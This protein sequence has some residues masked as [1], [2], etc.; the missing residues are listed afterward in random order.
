[1]DTF[2]TKKSGDPLKATEW[3]EATKRIVQLEGGFQIGSNLGTAGK[4]VVGNTPHYQRVVEVTG[5]GDSDGMYKC[6]YRYYA[7]GDSGAT[8]DWVTAD[9]ECD[10]D[11]RALDITLSE[12][13]KIVAYYDRQRGAF[14]P[15]A[16]VAAESSPIIRV[17]IMTT[18]IVGGP[19]VTA[20]KMEQAPIPGSYG[21]EWVPVVPLVEYQVYHIRSSAMANNIAVGTQCDIQYYADNDRWVILNSDCSQCVY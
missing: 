9:G 17:T 14:V 11:A 3:N 15:C 6:S 10:L 13:D 21:L 5:D 1:M 4:T 19:P 12:G 8:D 2:E 20:L 18:A 16:S 7:P